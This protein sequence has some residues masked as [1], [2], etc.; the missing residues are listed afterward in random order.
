MGSKSRIVCIILG[1]CIMAM[2][3][4]LLGREAFD[5]IN[6]KQEINL[7]DEE[8]NAVNEDEL[9]KDIKSYMRTGRFVYA[10]MP[11]YNSH[12]T[13]PI[14]TGVDYGKG[15]S[16]N[17][18]NGEFWIKGRCVY[19]AERKGILLYTIIIVVLSIIEITLLIFFLIKRK[20]NIR[21]NK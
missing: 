20:K 7:S 16:A 15:Y 19:K 4:F 13:S 1:I 3:F 8:R 5:I 12:E 14:Y 6:I 9:I 18:F 10:K 2:G 21:K 11:H 17:S